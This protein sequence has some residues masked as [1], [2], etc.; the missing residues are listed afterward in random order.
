MQIFRSRE[1]TAAMK[2]SVFVVMIPMLQAKR[3]N[4]R[5]FVASRAHNTKVT[6]RLL[7]EKGTAS[8]TRYILLLID[9]GEEGSAREDVAHECSSYDTK[10]L[11]NVKTVQMDSKLSQLGDREGGCDGCRSSVVGCRLSL[12]VTPHECCCS[13]SEPSAVAVAVAVAVDSAT[14]SNTE[15]GKTG[16]PCEKSLPIRAAP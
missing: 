2:M 14:E 12:V 8:C 4:V 1:S 9:Y 3:V 11:V 5:C 6:A 10:E 16:K 15:K 7:A 13:R